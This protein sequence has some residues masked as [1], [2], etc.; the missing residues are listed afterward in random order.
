MSTTASVGV[1]PSLITALEHIP[2]A[3]PRSSSAMSDDLTPP[4]PSPPPPPSLGNGDTAQN[5]M[6]KKDTN[7]ETEGIDTY[8]QATSDLPPETEQPESEEAEEQVESKPK[9]Q[10]KT[11]TPK[12]RATKTKPTD[13]GED[14]STEQVEP[15]KVT[16]K[17]RGT[18]AQAESPLTDLD[19]GNEEGSDFGEEAKPKKKRA[20]K[21]T[22]K[23]SRIA[24]DEPE[25]DED[26]NEIVKKKRKP[27]EYPKIEYEIPPVERKE[28]NFKGV[29]RVCCIWQNIDLR[30][31]GL[32][33]PQ[34]RVEKY[35]AG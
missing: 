6:A 28:T 7:G 11:A 10:R 1:Q 20:K 26:G 17:K 34:Y 18:K 4:P 16:P 14:E 9:R 5:N 33:L 12:K 27:R 30:T 31:I 25:F 23:K 13:E 35:K 22:P 24:K 2:P 19:G 32:C 29:S 8:A 21:A 15:P 3:P